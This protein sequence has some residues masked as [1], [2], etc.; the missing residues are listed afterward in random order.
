MSRDTGRIKKK[1][2]TIDAFFRKPAY[3]TIILPSKT[4]PI[5][6][7]RMFFIFLK[8]RLQSKLNI[9]K[10]LKSYYLDPRNG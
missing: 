2:R 1:T 4:R 7:L 5:I 8:I 9:T 3:R 6:L 10:K